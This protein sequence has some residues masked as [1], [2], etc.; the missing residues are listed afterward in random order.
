M[1]VMTIKIWIPVLLGIQ[2]YGKWNLY[3]IRKHYNKGYC[4]HDMFV[5][6][7]T[8]LGTS[9]SLYQCMHSREQTGQVYTPNIP[10]FYFNHMNA[11]NFRT[12]P[13]ANL[14]A[15]K[16][17]IAYIF[18]IPSESPLRNC[19]GTV[20]SLQ[21]CYQA[22]N[23][24]IGMNQFVFKFLSLVKNG[25]DFTVSDNIRISTIPQNRMCTRWGR[26]KQQIICCDNTSLQPTNQFII[27]PTINYSFGVVVR[28]QRSFRLLTFAPSAMK[29]HVG[30]YQ[31]SLGTNSPS[32]TFTLT[33]TNCIQSSSLLLL[34][35]FMS[36]NGSLLLSY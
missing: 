21:Y 6:T 12:G 29:Y 14:T 36:K 34:R 25:L 5:I 15:A 19:S 4:G 23:I 33:D 35:F 27:P 17:G 1:E 24:D 22:R 26:Q 30:Q 2:F 10:D 18:P 31:A 16:D 32:G 20:V 9:E 13:R 28:N 3:S 11:A 8:A 7:A